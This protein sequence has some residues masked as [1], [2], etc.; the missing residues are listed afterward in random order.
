MI[1]KYAYSLNG[2]HYH[3]VF[4]TRD[5]AITAGVST[6]RLS[7]EPPQSIFV[8]KRLAA[9]ARTIGHARSTIARMAGYAREQF[10][11]AGSGFLSNINQAQAGDLDQAL[12]SAIRAWLDKNH[13]NPEF[14]KIG[15]IGEYVVPPPASSRANGSESA[16]IHEIGSGDYASS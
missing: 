12:S 1:G 9:E 7:Q 10:G 16:E 8:G 2:E 15:A 6:A 3:G 11:D 14:G 4:D 5:E 13:L